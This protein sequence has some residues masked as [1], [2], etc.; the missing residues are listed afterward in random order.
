MIE[1]L[2]FHGRACGLPLAQ[3]EAVGQSLDLAESFI[4]E[5]EAGRGPVFASFV[6]EHGAAAA[7][8]ARRLAPLASASDARRRA[9][10]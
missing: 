2:E 9:T 7:A 10:G 3:L 6:L 4:L 8:F 1:V 5:S